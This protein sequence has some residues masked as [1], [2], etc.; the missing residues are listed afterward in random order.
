[1]QNNL[2]QIEQKLRDAVKLAGQIN[3]VKLPGKI[4]FQ[5]NI[6]EGIY[7]I[8]MGVEQVCNNMQG[9]DAAFEGW[10]LAFK[11]WLSDCKKIELDWDPPTESKECHYQRFLYRVINFID[12]NGAWFSVSERADQ[13]LKASTVLTP[14][15][16]FKA[17]RFVINKRTKVRPNGCKPDALNTWPKITENDLEIYFAANPEQLRTLL[18]F[19]GDLHR[20]IPTGVFDGIKSRKTR[21][22]PGQ[23]SAIDLLGFGKDGQLI[24]VELKKPGNHKVGAISE[25]LFYSTL[26]RDIQRKFITVDDSDLLFKAIPNTSKVKALFLVKGMHPLISGKM[27]DFMNYNY[28]NESIEFKIASYGDPNNGVLP[29]YYC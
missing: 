8:K 12:V 15:R 19:G 2:K 28:R 11:V 7:S 26:M 22:F 24:V 16:T 29:C 10:A 21:I 3:L 14:E 4:D 18:S 13:L 23:K 20:Q 27:I 1:M 17:G 6:D 9:D 25:I 5:Q